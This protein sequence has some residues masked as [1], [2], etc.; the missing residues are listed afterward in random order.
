MV[1]SSQGSSFKELTGICINDSD[2]IFFSCSASYK[3]GNGF[4]SNKLEG[5]KASPAHLTPSPE[6]RLFQRLSH[7]NEPGPVKICNI[8]L[9]FKLSLNYLAIAILIIIRLFNPK[10]LI[11]P[12]SGH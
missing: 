3:S 5:Q 7:K 12:S 1:L 9:M 6:K 10:L 4:L 2:F 8:V 11:E